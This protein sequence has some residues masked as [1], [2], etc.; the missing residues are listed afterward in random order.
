MCKY[1]AS[2]KSHAF[3]FLL[4]QKFKNISNKL[5]VA[6]VKDRAILIALYSAG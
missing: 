5:S 6:V 3:N 1:S 4:K 2:F